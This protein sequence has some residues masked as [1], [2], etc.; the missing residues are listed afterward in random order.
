MLAL[1]FWKMR[2]TLRNALG[3]IVID[4][5]TPIGMHIR[6]KRF[7]LQMNQEDAAKKL[8]VTEACVWLWENLQAKPQ[9][10]YMPA[11]IAFLG[12]CPFTFDLSTL[13]GRIKNYRIIHGLNSEALGKLVGVSDST[14]GEWENGTKPKAGRLVALQKIIGK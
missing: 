11:I 6:K 1:P 7:E 4:K 2:K 10:H 14:I 5:D 12:Y 3:I 9:I 8:G 13:A